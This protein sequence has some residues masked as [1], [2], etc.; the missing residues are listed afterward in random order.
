MEPY[1]T[2]GQILTFMYFFLIFLL[3]VVNY[4]EKLLVLN[5]FKTLG[6]NFFCTLKDVKVIAIDVF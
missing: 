5:N 2:L 4:F 1:L 6:F 3:R